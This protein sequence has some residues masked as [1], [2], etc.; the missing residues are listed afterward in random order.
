MSPG[1]KPGKI[2]KVDATTVEFQFEVPYF[3]LIEMLAGDT[4][5]GGG[6]SVGMYQNRSF[7][8]Y[9]PAHYLKQFLPKYSSEAQVNTRARAEGLRELGAH[10]AQQEGLE[11]QS[12]A[13]GDR[14]VAHRAAD[15]HADLGDGAQSLLLRGRHRRGT[16]CPTSTR[17]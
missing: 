17:S 2:V 1:G 13:A 4:L 16:S 3:L 14:P 7:G 11:P 10:A 12:R 6:M 15:Q 9:A 5:I 8:C